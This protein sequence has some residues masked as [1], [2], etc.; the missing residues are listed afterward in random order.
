MNLGGAITII[1][2]TLVDLFRSVLW[3]CDRNLGAIAPTAFSNRPPGGAITRSAYRC[4]QALTLI[5]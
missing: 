4:V 5:M 3:S 1:A 2:Y